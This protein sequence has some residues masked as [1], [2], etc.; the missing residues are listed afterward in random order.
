LI[1]ELKP[2]VLIT[3]NGPGGNAAN[4]LGKMNVKIF[5]GAGGMSIREAYQAYQDNQL[6][7][8]V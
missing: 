7:E 4:V 2:E 1:Y 8:G 5:V 3:G 6:K